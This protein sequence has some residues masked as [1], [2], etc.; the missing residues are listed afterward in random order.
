MVIVLIIWRSFAGVRRWPLLP[1][2]R[3]RRQALSG[4]NRGFSPPVFNLPPIGGAV[5]NAIVI[6]GVCIF[7]ATDDG[8]GFVRFHEFKLAVDV[9]FEFHFKF[10]FRCLGCGS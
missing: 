8:A 3:K 10:S 6:V 4:F 9:V 5:A 2:A 7:G 1:R